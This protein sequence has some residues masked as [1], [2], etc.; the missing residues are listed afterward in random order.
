MHTVVRAAALFAAAFTSALS[1]RAQS[2]APAAP[3]TA[4]AAPTP[5]PPICKAVVFGTPK[6]VEKVMGE[7]Y[8]TG[9]TQFAFF[10][11]GVVCG[12]K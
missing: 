7:L 12:W 10:G 3:A 6:E 9:R 1:L 5:L 2:V 4:E 8:A 11:N